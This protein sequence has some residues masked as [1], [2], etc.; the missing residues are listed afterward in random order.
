MQGLRAVMREAF[1]RWF[2]AS[3]AISIWARPTNGYTNRKIKARPGAAWQKINSVDGFVQPVLWWTP[4][5]LLR[6]LSAHGK[7]AMVAA[8][9]SATMP[10][11]H[12]KSSRHKASRF[13]LSLATSDPRTLFAGTL[14]GFPV[15]RRRGC[16]GCDQPSRQRLRDSE[17]SRSPLTQPTPTSSTRAL[18]TCLGRPATVARPGTTSSRG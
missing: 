13:T 9:G 15:D 18:G 2:R 16:L 7:T 12:F 1:A 4:P 14:Q 11:T 3:P 17:L 6:S 8:C 5:I 10:A